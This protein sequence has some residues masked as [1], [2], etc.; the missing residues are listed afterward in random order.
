M[1]L[2][3]RGVTILEGVVGSRAHG[4]DHP[5]SDTD[6]MQVVALPTSDLLGLTTPKLTEH[7]AVP[8]GDDSTIYEIRDLI[9]HSLKSAPGALEMLWLPSHTR[10]NEH[11][12]ELIENRGRFL[13]QRIRNTA[14]G[15]LRNAARS[16]AADPSKLTAKTHRHTYR[17]VRQAMAS[18]QTG[19]FPVRLDE[20]SIAEVRAFEA[21]PDYE[22]LEAASAAVFAEPTCLPVAPDREWAER[23]LLRVRAANYQKV[24]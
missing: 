4:L 3:E 2:A 24:C 7:T 23:F 18:W 10:M 19:V 15:I 16:H 17:M 8:G 6:R 22:S 20:T 1:G 5:G 13:A 11:G 14:Q 12:K 21:A 9:G